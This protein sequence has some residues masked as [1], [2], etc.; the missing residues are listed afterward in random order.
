MNIIQTAT[1]KS[2][3][4][5]NMKEMKNLLFYYLLFHAFH[6]NEVEKANLM[7]DLKKYK[8]INKYMLIIGIQ[9]RPASVFMSKIPKQK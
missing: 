1:I 7:L 5:F 4:A 9:L 8:A 3:N 6:K 2:L